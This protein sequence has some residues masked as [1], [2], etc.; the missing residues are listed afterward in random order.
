MSK[1]FLLQNT[2]IAAVIALTATVLAASPVLSQEDDSLVCDGLEATIVGT[3]GDDVLQGT[4]QD[5]VIV[6]LGGNDIIRGG[7]GSDTICGGDGNDEI[8]GESQGD[9]IVA[10]LQEQPLVPIALGDPA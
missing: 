1:R 9:I 7:S 3:A 6:G 8:H 4:W 2:A 10:Q 5:D